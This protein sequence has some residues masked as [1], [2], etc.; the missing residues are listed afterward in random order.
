MGPSCSSTEC[1]WQTVMDTWPGAVSTL[2]L[3]QGHLLGLMHLGVCVLDFLLPSGVGLLVAHIT[4]FG[5]LAGWWHRG[6]DRPSEPRSGFLITPKAGTGF[7]LSPGLTCRIGN[8]ILSPGI[9]HER[10]ES[11]KEWSRDMLLG[12]RNWHS[13]E[14]RIP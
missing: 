9:D 14:I 5:Y 1:G 8:S 13:P 7:Q 3:G 6:Q 10:K 12:G 4:H 2:L 11:K